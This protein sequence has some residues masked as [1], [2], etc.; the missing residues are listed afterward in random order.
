MHEFSI[1][2]ALFKSVTKYAIANNAVSVHAINIKIGQLSSII[3]ESVSFY[4]KMISEKSICE[5]AELHFEHI[6]GK[7]ICLDCNKEFEINNDLTPCPHC[8]GINLKTIGGMEFLLD[9]IEIETG[10]S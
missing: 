1:T 2:E 5:N 9:S 7:I 8:G 10:D 3:D 6:P 4:W